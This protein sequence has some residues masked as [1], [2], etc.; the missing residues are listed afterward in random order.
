MGALEPCLDPVAVSGSP[1]LPAELGVRN[2]LAG[3]RQ[4]SKAF[5]AR[6]QGCPVIQG[7]FTNVPVTKVPF[8]Q[9]PFTQAPFTQGPFT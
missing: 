2:G 3:E 9:A 1:E 6:E 5:A 7:P 8:T 4:L